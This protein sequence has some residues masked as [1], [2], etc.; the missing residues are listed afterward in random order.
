MDNALL[1][2]IPNTILNKLQIVQNTGARIITRTSR[3]SHITPVIKGLH[4]LPVKYRVQYKILAYAYK[5]LHGS[6]PI[7]I[8]NMIEVHR[9]VRNLRSTDTLSLVLP[10]SR[11][12]TYGNRSFV[13]T[14][15]KLWNSLPVNVRNADTLGSFKKL[16]KTHLFV[17]HFNT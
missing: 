6:S 4:W 2:G 16:L 7:Y 10:K 14:A 3:Q 9:H 15:P 8:R 11:S 13:Y 17:Q 5:A 1:N 12:V